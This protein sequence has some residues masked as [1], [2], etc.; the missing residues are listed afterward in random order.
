[1]KKKH[2]LLAPRPHAQR[3]SGGRQGADEGSN[4]EEWRPRRAHP[5]R[6]PRPDPRSHDLFATAMRR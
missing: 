3:C 1:M 5:F 6:E 2:K 4:A